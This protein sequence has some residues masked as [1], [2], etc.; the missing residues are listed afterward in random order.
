[1]S[2]LEAIAWGAC[3]LVSFILLIAYLRWVGPAEDQEK[4]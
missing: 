2:T 1:M 4:E 3:R